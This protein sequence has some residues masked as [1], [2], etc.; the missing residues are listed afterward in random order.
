MAGAA[1]L[2]RELTRSETIALTETQNIAETT[3]QEEAQ[4]VASAAVTEVG[5]EPP[6]V[7]K[8]W[9]TV[10]DELVRPAHVGADD[11]E[12]E[13]NRPFEV[14]GELLMYP[15]DDSLGASPGNIINCRCSAIYRVEGELRGPE[16][17]EGPTGESPAGPF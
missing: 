2:A 9:V 5:E 1:F 16:F 4:E 10:G 3:K 13:Q 7:L 11:Q 12:V 8:T 15:G 17:V 14:G 6:L